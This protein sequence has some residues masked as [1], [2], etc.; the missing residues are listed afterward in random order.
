MIN[1]FYETNIELPNETALSSWISAVISSE[2]KIEGEINFILCDDEYLLKINQDFLNHDTFTDII[3]FDNTMGNQL[4][5][6]IFISEERVV[7]NAKEFMVSVEEEM[8]RVL[9]HGILHF[10]GYKD[11]LEKEKK[12]MRQKENEKLLMFHVEH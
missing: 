3:S 5:G 8:R 7:E 1:F 9:I 11:K 12:L 2:N 10:C 6:D 4:N